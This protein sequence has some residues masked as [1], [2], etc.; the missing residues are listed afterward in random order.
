VAGVIAVSY[1]PVEGRWFR[2]GIGWTL[3]SVVFFAGSGYMR[4]RGMNLMHA[5]ALLTAWAALVAIP[6][7]EALRPLLPRRYFAWGGATRMLPLI[8][9]GTCLNGLQQ[10]VMNQSMKGKLSLAVPISSA[11]PVFVLLLSALFLRGV[12]RLNRRVVIG[13]IIA[14]AGMAAVG[15]GRHN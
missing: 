5:P 7:G 3:T 13:A 15:I 4:N 11:A 6:T 9:L 12:E 14:V 1:E 2:A 10:V 8:G